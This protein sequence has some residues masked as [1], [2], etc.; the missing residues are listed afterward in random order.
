MIG[1]YTK[2]K[3]KPED[4][5]KLVE[6]LSQAARSLNTID[7][8]KLYEVG[9]DAVNPAITSVNEIWTNELAHDASLQTEEAKKLIPQAIPLLIDKPQ[10][11]KFGLVITT[12]LS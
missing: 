1:Y 5:N 2:F 8:C 3:T 10:Q 12:W 9:L 11:T 4:R 6:L 7:S